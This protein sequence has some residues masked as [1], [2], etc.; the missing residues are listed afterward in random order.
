MRY[1]Y[2]CLLAAL[3]ALPLLGARPAQAKVRVVTAT[4][5]LAWV[6]DQIG[7][8]L[9]STDYLTRG[10]Q[11]PHMIDPRPS[12]VARLSR[13]D[14][15]V[16]IGMDLDLW[17]D[18][19]VDAARNPKINRGGQGYVDAH[20]GLR[21]LEIPSGKLDPSMGDIHVYGNPHYEFSP[22]AM[23]TVVARN[24]MEG[25]SRVDSAH[26]STYRANYNSLSQRIQEAEGRWKAKLAPYRGRSVVTYHK[27]FPYLLQYFG[28]REFGNVEP[29]PGIKPSA[30][31]VA[32][33]AREMKANGVKVII[34]ESYRSRQFSDLLARLSGGT[35]VPIPGGVGGE[36]G[37]DSY[38]SLMDAIVNRIA[39]A[40][41]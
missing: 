18:A 37:I 35:V 30:G 5:N 1:R 27:T 26:A 19:L 7:G 24:I 17:M 34:A 39:Q 23:R 8:N 21:P 12:Q 9:V 25:L 10:D 38:F 22:E 6:T 32:E 28:L 2:F 4:D 33:V 31:H 15:L 36:R 3:L 16:R 13:A 14:M 11:D 41:A 29:K 20:V 40:M